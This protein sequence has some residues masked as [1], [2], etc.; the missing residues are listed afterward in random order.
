MINKPKEIVRDFYRSD[1]LNDHTVIE[2]F[3]H[4][5]LNLVWNSPIGLSII[6]Y[7]ELV[8]FFDEIRR[9]YNSLRV[10]ISHILAD[11]NYI[12]VRYKYYVSTIENPDEELGIAHFISIW[13]IKDGKIYRGHQVSQ[14]VTSYDEEIESYHR[15]KV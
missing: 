14:P 4:P 15:V 6:H 10:E 11:G 8:S 3:F 9:T 13:E 12:T 1:I 7:N 2:R 5:D